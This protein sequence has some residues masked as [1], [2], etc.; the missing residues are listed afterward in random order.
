[1]MNSSQFTVIKMLRAFRALRTL[2]S[3]T[4]VRGARVI[5]LAIWR[6]QIKSLANVIVI[7]LIFLL[8]AMLLTYSLFYDSQPEPVNRKVEETFGCMMVSVILSYE[9]HTMK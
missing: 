6:S 8:L 7:L 4:L 5:L 2:K 1:M 3:L 9:L